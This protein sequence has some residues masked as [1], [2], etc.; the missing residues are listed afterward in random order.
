MYVVIFLRNMN[1]NEQN[2]FE[3]VYVHPYYKFSPQAD[4]YDVAVL[5]LDRPIRYAPHIVPICLPKKN[6]LTMEGTEA[7]VSG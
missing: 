4:R 2:S 6:E 1:W 3:K 5:K 7:M